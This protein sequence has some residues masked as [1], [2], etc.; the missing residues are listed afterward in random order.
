MSSARQNTTA[1]PADQFRRCV[2]LF[3]TGVT[4]V[5]VQHEGEYAGMT[6]NAFSSVSLTPLLVSV[7]L[8]HGTRTLEL[9]RRSERFAVS[10]LNFEQ[11][12]VA[13]SFAEPGAPFP[14]HHVVTDHDGHARIDRALAYIAC[15]V[16]QLITAGDHDIVV[17]RVTDLRAEEGRPLVFHGGEFGL[18][19][20]RRQRTGGARHEGD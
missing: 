10:I 11:I 17:G 8:A 18:I 4:I 20:Q 14:H 16:S 7:S 12:D 3:A 2:G 1:S 19:Q 13:R 5:A 6:L 15:D 9:V